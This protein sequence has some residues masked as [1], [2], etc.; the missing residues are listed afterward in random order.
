MLAIF[1]CFVTAFTPMT[2]KRILIRPYYDLPKFIWTLKFAVGF[3]ALV[4]MQLY[5]PAFAN[6]ELK[7]QDEILGPHFSG[8]YLIA[9]AFSTT[10]TVE[11]TW[12]KG[13]LRLLGTCGG[14]FCGWLAVKACGDDNAIGLGVWWT[15]ANTIIAYVSLPTGFRSRFGIDRKVFICKFKCSI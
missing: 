6:L 11:G 3:T 14:G 8:W 7:T 2:W 1:S 5:W 12:K 15:I 4:C 10:S 13:T 9:Y